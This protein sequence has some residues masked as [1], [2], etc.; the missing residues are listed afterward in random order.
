MKRKSY[1]PMPCPIAQ[2]L[3]HVGEWWSMLILRDAMAGMTRFEQFETSL[4]ISPS[5]LS[6]RL[7][8][9]IENGFMERIQYCDTPIRMAY[10]LTAR[11]QAFAPVLAAL[12]TFGTAHFTT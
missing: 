9:L 11:G 3:E 2:T 12:A 6:R 4:G 10:H 7:K 5:I 1:K 8:T